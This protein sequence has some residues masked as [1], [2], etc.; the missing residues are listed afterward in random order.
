MRQKGRL[1]SRQNCKPYILGIMPLV[2]LLVAIPSPVLAAADL[3]QSTYTINS[4][5]PASVSLTLKFTVHLTTNNTPRPTIYFVVPGDNFLRFVTPDDIGWK[6]IGTRNQESWWQVDFPITSHWTG[7]SPCNDSLCP[8]VFYPIE[9]FTLDIFFAIEFPYLDFQGNVQ[10]P[11][12][13]T[14]SGTLPWA[15]A[16]LPSNVSSMPMRGRE[17]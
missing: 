13:S 7:I 15:D 16:A 17:M 11:Y 8:M 1:L 4:V 9:N 12:F 3:Y 10:N 2:A 6:L 14:S 5:G